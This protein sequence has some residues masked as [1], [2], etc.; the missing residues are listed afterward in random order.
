[1]SFTYSIESYTWAS[2]ALILAF[3]LSLSSVIYKIWI[4]INL[5]TTADY[6]CHQLLCLEVALP[7]TLSSPHTNLPQKKHLQCISII[8]K[9]SFANP[10]PCTGHGSVQVKD[11]NYAVAALISHT[12]NGVTEEQR[13]RSNGG[14]NDNQ[15]HITSE[16]TRSDA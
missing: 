10:E 5:L 6:L 11:S 16:N 14:E 3:S 2:A 8:V 7:V 15:T 4:K 13:K 1:M 9:T 12:L